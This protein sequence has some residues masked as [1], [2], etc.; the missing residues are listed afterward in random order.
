MN[1]PKIRKIY[2]QVLALIAIP[3]ILTGCGKKSDCDIK[4]A[5]V[6]KYVN[7]KNKLV[8]YMKSENMG[9]RDYDWQSDYIEITKDDENFFKTKGDLFYG[10][11]NWNYLYN[12]MAARKDYLEFYYEYT[13]DDYISVIDEDGNDNGYWTTTTHS[14]WTNNPNDSD[15]TGRMRI[16]HHRY[17]GYRIVYQNGKYVK[18]KS[19]LVDD[20]KDI[21]YD[22]PY[23]E[24][25]CVKI[26]NKEYRFDRKDL[27]KLTTSDFDVFKGPDLSNKE[28]T[29]NT[30]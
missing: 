22:Y 3:F 15:N 9:Y 2:K 1:K 13:T 19:P 10:P 6:H 29:S 5:H 12:K 18:E 17:Y 28:L 30:K 8:T 11:D 23:F 26:V 21:V 25:D 20:I 16:C 27:P 24:E 4:E 14:G 7:N